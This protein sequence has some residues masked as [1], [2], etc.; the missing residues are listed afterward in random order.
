MFR[1]WT[2]YTMP[3]VT[4]AKAHWDYTG[5]APCEE[6]V[7]MLEMPLPALDDLEGSRIPDSLPTVVD[8]HVH[9][10]PD[11]FFQAIWSWFDHHAWPIRYRLSSSQIVEFL[12]NKGVKR[13][14]GLHYAHKPCI[15]RSLNRYMADLCSQYPEVI[16]TATVF[17]GEEDAQEILREGFQQGLAG[18]KLHAH[19]QCFHMDSAAMHEIYQTCAVHNKPLVMHVGREPKNPSFP[20]PVDPYVTCRAD[21]L[22][23]VLKEYPGLRVCVPHLGANEYAEYRNMLERYDNLWLDNAMVFADYLPKNNPPALQKMR[24]D[25]IMYGTDFPNIPYAWDREM[26]RLCAS[27]LSEECLERVLGGNC[28]DL[29]SVPVDGETER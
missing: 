4:V 18:V 12:L 7:S 24:T 26:K 17:P 8:A 15:A 6:E 25:R 19:V 13:M 10:F 22:E 3:P 5:T 28:L 16:G 1:E 14:V 20:Y 11:G 21:K 9:L 23:T 27:D 29:F 2:K